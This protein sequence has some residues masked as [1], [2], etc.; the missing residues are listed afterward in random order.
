VEIV[1]RTGEP[2]SNEDIVE[3]IEAIKRELVKGQ[4]NPVMVFYPI[5]LDALVELL[6]RRITTK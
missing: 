1:D 4:I 3:A 5:V 6:H 2:R